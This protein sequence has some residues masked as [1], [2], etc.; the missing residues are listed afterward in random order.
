[1]QVIKYVIECVLRSCLA[2]KFLY[3][4]NYQHIDALIKVDKVI[5]FVLTH[6][7]GILALKHRC[8]DIEYSA[9]GIVLLYLY[10]Y[11]FNEVRL[12]H[13]CRSE[14]EKRV[15]RLAIRVGCYR[16]TYAQRQLVAHTSAVVLKCVFRIE[17]RIDV[18][19]LDLR[20]W[21]RGL[22]GS[23]LYFVGDNCA[24][25]KS[26]QLYVGLGVLHHRVEV[27]QLKAIAKYLSKYRLENIRIL[28]F[29]RFGKIERRHLEQ[30]RVAGIKALI[31]DGLKPSI[32]L[33]LRHIILDYLKAFAPSVIVH[34]LLHSLLFVTFG[35]TKF[36]KT[37]QI[38]K[39][40]II[41]FFNIFLNPLNFNHLHT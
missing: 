11:R 17:L 33:G 18:G 8:G 12:A 35:D 7:R 25:V 40:F 37:F 23:L 39:S 19:I 21:I 1:M 9:P 29:E 27:A 6:C 15:K 32:I 34:F 2:G 30:Y 22:L 4:V 41:W 16:L 31:H 3:V 20:K 10:A 26:L 14:D 38:K 24:L 28:L 13:A 36:A 5:E